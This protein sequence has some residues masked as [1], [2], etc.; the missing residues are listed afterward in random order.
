MKLG[1]A[2]SVAVVLGAAIFVHV[3]AS[4]GGIWVLPLGV[5]GVPFVVA[6]MFRSRAERRRRFTPVRL[7]EGTISV[8]E[9]TVRAAERQLECPVTK[10][11]CVAWMA[12]LSN[13]RRRNAVAI[14]VPFRLELGSGEV[15]ALELPTGWRVVG[16]DSSQSQL[17]APEEMDGKVV[18][19]FVR[20]ELTRAEV[21]EGLG[22]LDG[23]E[24]L[25]LDP[26]VTIN[27]GDV[28]T[29]RGKFESPLPGNGPYRED[30]A[31]WRAKPVCTL[32]LGGLKERLSK[33]RPGLREELGLAVLV[34]G[35]V[36]VAGVAMAA[37]LSPL[38][39]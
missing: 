11:P 26:L 24:P 27:N 25:Q 18:L 10:R 2:F 38:L 16:A 8:I 34:A 36:E 29:V 31:V 33:T 7:G 9:G 17:V 6:W 12:G 3:L 1:D 32:A 5:L 13:V 15:V 21:T 20:T 14:C 4:R 39:G 30:E 35:L 28:V 37:L 23:L 19:D 22:F